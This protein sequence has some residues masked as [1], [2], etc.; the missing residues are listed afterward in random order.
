[1]YS[2]QIENMNGEILILTGN[3]P[4]YQIVNIIG[5]NP[6]AAQINTTTV[7]GLDGAKFNSSKLQTRNIVITVKINGEVE[8]NRLN[9]YNFFQTNEWCRF[10]YVNQTRNVYIDAYVDSFECDFFSNNETAQISLLCLQPYFKSLE[11]IYTD[12]SSTLAL[13]TFPFSINIGSPIP[14][15]SFEKYRITNVYND[16]ESTTGTD[17]EIEILKAVSTIEIKNTV[18][19]DDFMLNYGF[20]ENDRIKI[21]TNKGHK[22]VTLERN[23]TSTNIF[24]AIQKGSVFFTLAVGNNYFG[25]LVDGGSNNALVNIVFKYHEVYRGV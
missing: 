22:A 11:E 19:G 17:I 9:L 14:F 20:Q 18:T 8:T 25:Y 21:N 5:L 15:S 13:F 16:S 2:V 1:M 24:T 4:V 10:Y 6:P 3:E 7:V 12:I 23:G